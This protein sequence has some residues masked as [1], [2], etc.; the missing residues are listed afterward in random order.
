M[1][2]GLRRMRSGYAARGPIPGG[3]R[4]GAVAPAPA[5]RADSQA[6]PEAAAGRRQHEEAGQEGGPDQILSDEGW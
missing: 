1:L 2:H 5:A 4:C 6:R 3:R